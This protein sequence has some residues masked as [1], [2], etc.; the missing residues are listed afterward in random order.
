MQK[1]GGYFIMPIELF[2]EKFDMYT[3]LPKISKNY[4][5]KWYDHE[6]ASEEQEIYSFKTG[7]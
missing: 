2:I 3:V 4:T 7:N 6:N 5:T 1:E